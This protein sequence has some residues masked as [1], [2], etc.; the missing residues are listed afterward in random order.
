MMLDQ[1]AIN[2]IGEQLKGKG[3][4]KFA[5]LESTNEQIAFQALKNE[6]IRF[7]TD[8]N[9]LKVDSFNRSPLEQLVA[10]D[11]EVIYQKARQRIRNKLKI[12]RIKKAVIRFTESINHFLNRQIILTVVGDDGKIYFHNETNEK[13]IYMQS[14]AL[15]TG[16]FNLSFAN[17]INNEGVLLDLE[18]AED[19]IINNYFKDIE[20][21]GIDIQK[22]FLCATN[23]YKETI[24]K[25]NSKKDG[26]IYWHGPGTTRTYAYINN[27]GVLAEAYVA[28]LFT[29][30]TKFS[31]ELD[32]H[33]LK[34]YYYNFIKE[35]DT[36][37]GIVSA[38]ISEDILDKIQFAVKNMKASSQ[39]FQNLTFIAQYI[40]N[41]NELI[42]KQ[43]LKNWFI[44]QESGA[45][46]TY[47][48]NR[49]MINNADKKI[50]DTLENYL[51]DQNITFQYAL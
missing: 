12:S 17:N 46:K 29:K 4:K 27:G 35:V 22:T 3:S 49:L 38:D 6:A 39:R 26:F 34:Y 20:K 48:P 11:S 1:N 31:S 33:N 13:Q 42:T 41:S 37:A 30:N 43:D 14:S 36:R 15:P 44:E 40:I 10:E 7:M 24:S 8:I 32:P 51:N 9:N 21:H 23:R 50:S 28:A 19:S 25:G 45:N 47:F 2:A 16:N 18:Q 5:E